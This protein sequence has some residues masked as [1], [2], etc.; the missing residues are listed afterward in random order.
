[1]VDSLKVVFRHPHWKPG[2]SAACSLLGSCLESGL[3][4]S[5]HLDES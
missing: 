1:M 3:D 5:G 2:S 4:A